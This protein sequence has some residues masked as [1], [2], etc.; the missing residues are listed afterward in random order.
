MY[1]LVEIK[2]KQYKAEKGALLK[3][4][5]L[6]SEVGTEVEFDTVLMIGGDSSK[7]GTPYVAGAKVKTVIE[8]NIKDKKIRVFKYNRRKAYRR[9]Q[10]HRQQYSLVRVSDIVEA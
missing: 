10:G 4:D 5:S 9:T 1:A 8:H 7:I 3:V 6:K 2:G